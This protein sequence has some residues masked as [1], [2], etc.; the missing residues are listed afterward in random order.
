MK[1]ISV[2][3]AVFNA[4]DDMGIEYTNDTPTYTRW[5]IDAA[6]AIGGYLS[7]ENK[8]M[9]KEV[10]DCVARL[11]HNV[12]SVKKVLLGDYGCEC[13]KLFARCGNGIKW[14]KGEPID[15]AFMVVDM[16]SSEPVLSSAKWTIQDNSILMRGEY[17]GKITILYLAIKEDCDG[18]PMVSENSIQA[19]VN[20]ILWMYAKRSRFG[21]RP[22]QITDVRDL[23]NEWFTSKLEARGNDLADMEASEREEIV[24]LV[25]D[26]LVGMGIH[27]YRGPLD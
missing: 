9:V 12:V 13:D 24:A 3:N 6:K 11:P 8:I 22:M 20:Y 2:Q 14:V 18:W 1:L 17:V 25:N 19:I 21:K 4:F 26:P 5:A 16:P 23:R 10:K 15:T 7:Y 27:A